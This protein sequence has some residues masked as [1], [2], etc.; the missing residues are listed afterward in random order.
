MIIACNVD[1]I[2]SDLLL[3]NL[4]T[5]IEN[6]L[7]EIQQINRKL[8]SRKPLTTQA[9]LNLGIIMDNMKPESFAE[10]SKKFHKLDPQSISKKY[11]V[12]LS[13]M[14]SRLKII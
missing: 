6:K 12:Y 9:L 2:T 13:H 11:V 1:C 8:S 10:F 5:E 7:S 14:Y 3:M 4:T